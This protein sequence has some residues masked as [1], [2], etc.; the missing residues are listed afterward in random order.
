MK[1]IYRKALKQLIHDRDDVNSSIAHFEHLEKRRSEKTDDT[2]SIS[3]GTKLRNPGQ[4]ERDSGMIPNAIQDEGEQGF[5][6]E[7]EHFLAEPGIG[8]GEVALGNINR[9]EILP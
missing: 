2:S 7:A 1:Q 8:F 4:G 9:L 6:G 5:R 3:T